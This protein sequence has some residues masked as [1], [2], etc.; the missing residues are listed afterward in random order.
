MT[1]FSPSLYLTVITWPSTPDTVVS[2]V[3][4]VMV[5]PGR[6]HGRW[7][8]P[9][10]RC[11]SAKIMI[12]MARCVPSACGVAPTP[13]KT[14]GLISARV[15]LTTPNTA[16]LSATL[17]LTSPASPALTVMVE[18]STAWIGPRIRTVCCAKAVEAAKAASNAT[19]AT[20]R[21][22][23]VFMSL[24]PEI[25]ARRRDTSARLRI[26]T[27]QRPSHRP[28]DSLMADRGGRSLERAIV[29]LGS[30]V[31]EDLGAGL[32]LALVARN[33]GHDHGL[34]RHDDLLLAVLVLER[35]HVAV[36]ALDHLRHGG[37]G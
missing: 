35:D 16:T 7:P 13:M 8:S 20:T 9:V 24:P 28:H 31:D 19:P 5:V 36:D 1:F 29:L 12:W 27:K 25:P 26:Q 2:T 14:P 6:S 3:A 15:A 17:T 18:P 34:R 33:I 30:R 22:A 21:W 32:E 10:P 23:L 37:V 11:D 4:L